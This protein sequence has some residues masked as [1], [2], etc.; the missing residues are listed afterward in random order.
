MNELALFEQ[1]QKS[2]AFKNI[3]GQQVDPRSAAF[4]IISVTDAQFGAKGDGVTDDAAAF[5]AAMTASQSVFVPYSAS[6]YAI[7]STLGNEWANKSGCKL[8]VE[9]GSGPVTATLGSVL[10]WIGAAS[11]TLLKLTGV[12]DSIFEN[13]S[14][15][16]GSAPSTL[17][18]VI[19]VDPTSHTQIETNNSFY[20]LS[21]VQRGGATTPDGSIA[22]GIRLSRSTSPGNVDLFNFYNLFVAGCGTA[23]VSIEHSQSKKHRF[24]SP[25]IIFSTIGITNNLNSSSG[26]SYDVFGGDFGSNTDV[27]LRY[28]V[29]DDSISIFGAH[30]ESSNRFFDSTG[31]SQGAVLI[32]GVSTAGAASLNADGQVVRFG[33]NVSNGVGQVCIVGCDFYSTDNAV[34][35][36]IGYAQSNGSCFSVIGT[37][38]NNVT[39]FVN[40]G[41]GGAA[42]NF[43]SLGNR[44]WDGSQYRSLGAHGIR[45]TPNTQ[46]GAT[47]TVLAE[48]TDIIANRA[49]TVTL[50]LETASGVP[51]KPLTVRTIQAQTV[52]SASAN[53]V[54][55]VGGA[56]GTAILAATAGKWATLV[57]DGANW[58]IMEGN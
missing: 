51:G 6:G 21:I 50:T 23:A 22:I 17:A 26:G 18:A 4:N 3:I 39:P 46:T 44:G 12:R 14:F 35:A 34:A 55:L 29:S 37:N 30:S 57:S 20:N 43:I 53:V 16:V 32:Q 38:F 41:G 1:D 56:A 7:G 27:D 36:K 54:P 31:L 10:K 25:N 9:L 5:K 47:Y 8:Y 52:V 19:D 2:F 24:Y 42:I 45:N 40:N 48:D 58:Q 28:N 13:L 11:G 33:T 49:G 15:T